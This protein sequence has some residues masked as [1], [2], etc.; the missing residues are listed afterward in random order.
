MI[1]GDSTKISMTTSAAPG[2]DGDK[3]YVRI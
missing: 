2:A 3:E 1:S